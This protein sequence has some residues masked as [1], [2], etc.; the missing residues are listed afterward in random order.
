MSHTTRKICVLLN[1]FYPRWEFNEH[2]YKRVYF[3]KKMH[4]NGITPYFTFECIKRVGCFSFKSREINIYSDLKECLVNG[5]EK[6]E[7]ADGT[8]GFFAKKNI[9]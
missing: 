6:I 4:N 2:W 1:S 8:V 3:G 9:L 7:F 5:I